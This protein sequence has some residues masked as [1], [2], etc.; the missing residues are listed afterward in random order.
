MRCSDEEGLH[1]RRPNKAHI[2][3]ILLHSWIGRSWWS[4]HPT[5]S[6]KWQLG[7]LV[8]K[9]FNPQEIWRTGIQNW[10]VQTSRHMLK[11]GGV[12]Y[13]LHSF[14]LRSSFLSHWVLLDKVFNEAAS[15]RTMGTMVA[16]FFPSFRF[17]SHWVF[18]DKVFNEAP[19]THILLHEKKVNIQG[20]V[21]WSPNLW[22]PN[23][24][25]TSYLFTHTCITHI[26]YEQV[27]NGG[28]LCKVN[29]SP[30]SPPYFH[31]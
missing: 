26:M 27:Y 28:K 30:S 3:K 20:G 6:V 2:S 14:F 18:P 31:A 29:Y 19:S 22:S 9:V 15:R 25:T 21:L 24:H 7:W 11:S 23:Y 16:L 4:G 12:S 1:Q 13:A 5:N 10:N 8:H 17:L